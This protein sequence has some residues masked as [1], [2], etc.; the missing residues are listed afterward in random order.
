MIDA[1]RLIR[2]RVELAPVKHIEFEWTA[3]RCVSSVSR[4]LSLRGRLYSCTMLKYLCS[5]DGLSET[6]RHQETTAV[7]NKVF[8]A[9]SYIKLAPLS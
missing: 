9:E 7:Q 5:M 1:Q 4:R 6:K 3:L 2:G 8:V